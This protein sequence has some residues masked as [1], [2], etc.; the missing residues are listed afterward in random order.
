MNV[1]VGHLREVPRAS[2]VRGDTGLAL[3]DAA[4]TSH[5]LFVVATRRGDSFRASIRGHLIEVAD[6]SSDHGLAPTPDDLRIV[7]IASDLAWAARRF[8]RV[9]GL[10]DDV[11]VSAAWQTLEGS[12][13]VGDISV[14]VSVPETAETI[15]EALMAALEE[16]VAARSLDDPLRVHLHCQT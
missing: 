1:A 12:P 11:D 13:S 5:A 16:W 10:A 3:A 9:H 2:S 4:P 14:T 8:L 15:S 7:S 6:P